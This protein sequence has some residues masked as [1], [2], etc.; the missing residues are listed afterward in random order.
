MIPHDPNK[1]DMKISSSYPKKIDISWHKIPQKWIA[2][3]IYFIFINIPINLLVRFTQ[4][5]FGNDPF[6]QKNHPSSLPHSLVST[7]KMDL[8][9]GYLT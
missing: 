4:G 2:I 6:H 7:N 1:M 3:S 8:P 9:S 5:I